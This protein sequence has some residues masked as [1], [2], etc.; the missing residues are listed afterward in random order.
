METQGAAFG[1]LEVTARGEGPADNGQTSAPSDSKAETSCAAAVDALDRAV[2]RLID[3]EKAV[4]LSGMEPFL[5]YPGPGVWTMKELDAVRRN[6]IHCCIQ[7]QRMAQLLRNAKAAA[8]PTGGSARQFLAAAATALLDKSEEMYELCEQLLTTFPCV[9]S[10]QRFKQRMRELSQKMAALEQEMRTLGLKVFHPVEVNTEEALLE[11]DTETAAVGDGE[12]QGEA[13][14]PEKKKADAGDSLL[15]RTVDLLPQGLA[16]TAF[17]HAGYS[18]PVLLGRAISDL[19]AAQQTNGKRGL[20][21]NIAFL[22]VSLLVHLRRLFI[23]PFVALTSWRLS[24]RGPKAWWRNP[25]CWYAVKLV[26]PLICIF[27]CG[28]CLPKFRKYSWGINLTERPNLL[29]FSE[30]GVTT[31]MVPWFM[32]GYLTVLQTT[33]NGTV[34]RA[35]CR[36]LGILL[37][38][39]S[40]W[41]GLKLCGSSVAGLIA[42]CAVTVFLDIFFFADSE[43]PL[44]GFHKTWGYAGVVFTYTQSL[45]VTLST[46][47][48]GGLT[49]DMNYVVV[50]RILSNLMGILLGVVVTHVPPL[51]SATTSACK[52][53]TH[54][55]QCCT[56]GFTDMTQSFL[57]IC[58]GGKEEYCATF[59]NE[60]KPSADSLPVQRE[61]AKVSAVSKMLDS[62]CKEH[63]QAAARYIREGQNL[64]L[65]LPWRTSSR[66]AKVHVA[67]MSMMLETLDAAQL[68]LDILNDDEEDSAGQRQSNLSPQEV[69]SFHDLESFS[70]DDAAKGDHALARRLSMP[71]MQRDNCAAVRQVFQTAKGEEALRCMCDA[72]STL[73]AAADA[74]ICASLPAFGERLMN[75]G[76]GYAQQGDSPKDHQQAFESCRAAADRNAS[77]IKVALAEC[78]C[79]HRGLHAEARAARMASAFVVMRLLYHLQSVTFSLDEV[80]AAL[81]GEADGGSPACPQSVALRNLCEGK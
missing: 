75:C 71:L 49:G 25:E 3:A 61:Q 41:V 8:T 56:T 28:I 2:R 48:N 77:E 65:L 42:F 59:D 10:P 62:T 20:L 15:Q 63:L 26:V 68:M 1:G 7:T 53:Y 43:H 66:L 34:H 81:T 76:A 39:F 80:H 38:S 40:G 11:L 74:E 50:T 54:V 52:E 31:R 19:A 45:V 46:E 29:D 57:C 30:A 27:A 69:L 37:G 51:A 58:G 16:T 24:W 21:L 36:T 67:M 17:V 44:D 12:Q 47:D 33:Y 79:Q 13:N 6:L 4:L 14:E 32:L 35:I 78:L 60:D 73:A 9:F 23:T 55:M 18:S 64:P 72:I 22:F 70:P 5:L